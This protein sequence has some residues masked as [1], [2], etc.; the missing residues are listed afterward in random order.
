MKQLA[1]AF[2][3]FNYAANFNSRLVEIEESSSQIVAGML[4]RAKAI[5]TD[6][7]GVRYRVALRLYE[8]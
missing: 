1:S 8:R 6:A 4:Y 5:M 7:S 3:T 2:D